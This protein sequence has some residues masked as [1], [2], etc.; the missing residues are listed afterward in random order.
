MS[1]Q[2]LDDRAPV[3][4]DIDAAFAARN[5]YTVRALA[6]LGWQRC[7]GCGRVFPDY[8]ISFAQWPPLCKYRVDEITPCVKLEHVKK[9]ILAFRNVAKRGVAIMND[10]AAREYR[11][12]SEERVTI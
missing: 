10:S 4:A 12:L 2:T 11:A 3:Y 9:R 1:T 6:R 8:M 7:D 5:C